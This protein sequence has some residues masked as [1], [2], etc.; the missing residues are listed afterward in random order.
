MSVNTWSFWG[1]SP[2]KPW[3]LGFAYLVLALPEI[4]FFPRSRFFLSFILS[5]SRL[6]FLL[7]Y[8]FAYF[9]TR[10]PLLDH[11]S[12]NL[13]PTINL[14]ISLSAL[15]PPA[16]PEI[17]LELPPLAGLSFST[18]VFSC[19]SALSLR[20]RLVLGR[21]VDDRYWILNP[22]AI[23]PGRFATAVKDCVPHVKLVEKET[24]VQPFEKGYRNCLG[25]G[26]R[27]SRERNR[28]VTCERPWHHPIG[29][30]FNPGGLPFLEK[31]RET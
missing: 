9:N 22:P 20:E 1:T 5:P 10:L 7:L 25:C 31:K 21:Q 29:F 13:S 18:L 24:K 11:L 2:Y 4:F 27:P 8:S 19:G 12:R 23:S 3:K 28:S 26:S 6:H 17:H 16:G 15:K 14:L 30:A